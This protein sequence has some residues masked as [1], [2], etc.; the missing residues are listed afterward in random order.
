MQKEWQICTKKKGRHKIKK[1]RTKK[2][3]ELAKK[4]RPLRR[5][6]IKTQKKIV[7]KKRKD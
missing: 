7:I 3:R 4:K 1:G 2:E 5:D 6:N